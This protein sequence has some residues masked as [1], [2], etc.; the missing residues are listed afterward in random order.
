MSLYVSSSMT[1][2]HAGGV[3]SAV[4]ELLAAWRFRY[5]TRHELAL[6][7]ERDLHDLGLSRSDIAAEIDKPF[8]RA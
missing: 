4:T 2:H 5:R 8:W 1:K 3:L 6:W 7:S